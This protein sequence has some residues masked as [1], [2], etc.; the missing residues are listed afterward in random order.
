MADESPEESDADSAYEKKLKA[1]WQVGK[2]KAIEAAGN[3]GKTRSDHIQQNI[4]LHVMVGIL[5]LV[6]TAILFVIVF[7]E[8]WELLDL[9]FG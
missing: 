5:V 6:T 3:P 9:L 7:W 4:K 8:D 2:E 1:N